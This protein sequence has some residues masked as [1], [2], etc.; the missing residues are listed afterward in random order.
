MSMM[1]RGR[2]WLLVLIATGAPLPA[3]AQGPST[4]RAAGPTNSLPAREATE[5]FSKTLRVAVSGAFDLTNIS[6]NVV[7]MAGEGRDVVIE[8][9]KRVQRPDPNAARALLEMIDIQVVE[10]RNRIDVRT[11]YPRPRNFP[12]SVDYTIMVPADANVTI[13]VTTGAIR[14]TGIRVDALKT[15]SGDI[16][17]VDASAVPFATASAVSG[18]ITVR[19]LKANAV[20]LTTV[21]G[22]LRVD[23]TQSDRLMA[24]A[25]SG[26][27]EFTGD[28]ARN[29]RYEFISHSGDVRLLLSDARGFEVQANSF[30]GTVQSDFPL[31]RRGRAE[32]RGARAAASTPR[33]LRGAFGDASAMVLV[34]AFSGNVS[35]TRR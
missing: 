9:V 27:V 21:T 30:S 11:V 13:K 19:G 35:I 20:Q 5:R 14:A 32:G 17:L 22:N 8:A 12:A 34:R 4:P 16:E 6:G 28:L 24:R 25:V 18:N 2:L 15:V 33:G 31:S 26:D 1:R 29:G 23:N 10:E 7:I 3:A